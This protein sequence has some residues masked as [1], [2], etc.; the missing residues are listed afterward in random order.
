MAKKKTVRKKKELIPGVSPDR[1]FPPPPKPKKRKN[2]TLT[3]SDVL[4]LKAR[5]EKKKQSVIFK[6]TICNEPIQATN[7]VPAF[8]VSQSAFYLCA[9]CTRGWF[10]KIGMWFVDLFVAF[11]SFILGK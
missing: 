7:V 6:C 10:G 4:K 1:P 2:R 11:K 8:F 5:N 3:R 9:K